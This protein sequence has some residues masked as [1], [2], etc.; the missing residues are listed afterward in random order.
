[1][2]IK[3]NRDEILILKYITNERIYEMESDLIYKDDDKYLEI[4]QLNAK[5]DGILKLMETKGEE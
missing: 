5:L 2:D 3:F 1:M 4:K